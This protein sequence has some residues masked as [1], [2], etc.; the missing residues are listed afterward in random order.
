M[1]KNISH[2]SGRQGLKNNLFEKIGHLSEHEGTLNKDQ[3]EA[4]AQEYLL[5]KANITG[6]I[7]AYDFAR[8]ENRGKKVYVCNGS[9]CMLAGTQD[10]IRKKLGKH[11]K[12]EEIG[13]M[14]C[15]GRCHENS[16]FNFNGTNYS[17]LSDEELNVVM[18]T[19]KTEA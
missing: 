5:G 1:S 9:A 4:L 10:A 15:L 7:S 6:T 2:L 13:N 12:E 11:F 19:Q 3:K 17:A 14:T 8:G 18:Q 16:A